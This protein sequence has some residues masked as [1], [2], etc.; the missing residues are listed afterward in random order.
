VGTRVTADPRRFKHRECPDCKGEAAR[1]LFNSGL[2]GHT[3]P[4]AT[5]PSA[6]N[7][8]RERK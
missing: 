7:K 6:S 8:S 1:P 5:P 2:L 4:L 3:W